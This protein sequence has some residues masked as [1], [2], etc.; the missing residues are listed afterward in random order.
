MSHRAGIV[1]SVVAWCLFG[2][3]LISPLTPSEGHPALVVVAVFIGVPVALFTMIGLRSRD[4]VT[5]TLAALQFGAVLYIGRRVLT[6]I[7]AT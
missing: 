2:V 1:L 7:F 3:G 4:G 5:R 6:L